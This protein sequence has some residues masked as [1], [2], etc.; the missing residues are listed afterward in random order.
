MSETELSK[1]IDVPSFR[2]GVEFAASVIEGAA[3]RVDVRKR[4][5]PHTIAILEDIADLV[6]ALGDPEVSQPGTPLN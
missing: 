4:T 5:G 2:A 6:R 1:A 3:G